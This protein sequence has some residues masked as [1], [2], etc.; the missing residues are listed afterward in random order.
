[1]VDGTITTAVSLAKENGHH[2]IVEIIKNHT[3]GGE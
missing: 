2:N 1:M 3:P